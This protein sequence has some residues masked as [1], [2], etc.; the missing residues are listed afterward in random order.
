MTRRKHNCAIGAGSSKTEFVVLFWLETDAV[1]EGVTGMWS[2]GNESR[3]K[4]ASSS[5]RVA[6]ALMTI[7][8]VAGCG[9]SPPPKQQAQ[10]EQEAPAKAAPKGDRVAAADH[11][12]RVPK[13]KEGGIPYDA[14]FD[15]PL[16]VV[17]D[18]ATVATATKEP[19]ASGEKP[20]EKPATTPTA[21]AAGS[22]GVAWNDLLPADILQAEAKKVLNRSKAWLQGQGTYNGNYKDISV[23]GSVMAA[24]AGVAAE[25]TA[26]VS[27][28]ANAPYIR[29]FGHEMAEAATGLGKD[30][31]EK[32]KVAFDKLDAIFSGTVP[33][34]AKKPSPT[35]PFHETASREGLMKRIDKAKNWMRDNINTEAKL[36]GES[37]AIV[38]EA[39]VIA[40]LGKIVAAEG[41]S[42]ADEADYQQFANALINGAKDA[43]AAAK[44]QSFQK[45][46]DS[47]NK[48]NKSCEQCHANYGS[49]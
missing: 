45:F 11:G 39:M 34:D 35:R 42:S 8:W 28:K 9:G 1:T 15:E 4:M 27:W 13:K 33:A 20:T 25:T 10:T 40:A 21:P 7:S 41:Y 49:N 26:E 22:G 23:D 44:D 32:S 48:V 47:M 2:F 31:Y 18:S 24:L 5:V 3:C 14:F 12:E 29:D 19:A 38:H 6:L 43:A 16:E 17:K 30:N 37:E 46:T 36:K